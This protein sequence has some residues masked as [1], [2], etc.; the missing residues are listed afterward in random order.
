MP[1]FGTLHWLGEYVLYMGTKLSQYYEV[2]LTLD[3]RIVF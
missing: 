3:R 2:Y 1:N